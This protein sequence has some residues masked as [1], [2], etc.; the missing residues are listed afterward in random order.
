M[1]I[2]DKANVNVYIM[3]QDNINKLCFDYVIF[4]L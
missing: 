2:K 1:P 4:A 3:L